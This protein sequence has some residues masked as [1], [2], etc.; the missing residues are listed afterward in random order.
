MELGYRVSDFGRVESW[1]KTSVTRFQFC[2]PYA[3]AVLVWNG[4]HVAEQNC[5]EVQ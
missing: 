5:A 3:V 1:V 2:R 4:W